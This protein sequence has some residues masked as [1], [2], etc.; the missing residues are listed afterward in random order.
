MAGV[1]KIKTPF[2]GLKSMVICGVPTLALSDQNKRKIIGP[3][4][5]GFTDVRRMY[6]SESMNGKFFRLVELSPYGL[7][8]VGQ[9]MVNDDG[10]IF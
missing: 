8:E 3:K 9:G 7:D 2:L 1:C 6:F 4:Q 5:W 10:C